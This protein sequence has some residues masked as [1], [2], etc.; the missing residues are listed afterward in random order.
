[1]GVAATLMTYLPRHSVCLAAPGALLAEVL[2]RGRDSGAK[3][4]ARQGR[5]AAN[6]Q[7]GGPSPEALVLDEATLE[8]RLFA[9]LQRDPRSKGCFERGVRAPIHE[10]ER[11]VPVMLAARRECL[12]VELD[13]WYHVREPDE[14][15][16]ARLKDIWLQRAGFLSLRFPAED[17]AH[18]LSSVVDEICAGLAGRRAAAL[19]I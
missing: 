6:P 12:L 2:E 16:R 13:R 17:I 7:L 1:M 14:Y 3:A 11:E 8:D 15:R 4:M 18:R 5:L 9:A 19:F 10:D